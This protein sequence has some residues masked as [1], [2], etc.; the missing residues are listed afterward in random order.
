MLEYASWDS[1]STFF[2]CF[3]WGNICGAASF[4]RAKAS[5]FGDYLGSFWGKKEFVAEY[6]LFSF[7]LISLVFL[8]ALAFGIALLITYQ[9]DKKTFNKLTS[10]IMVMSFLLH[11][12]SSAVWNRWDAGMKE[13]SGLFSAKNLTSEHTVVV[14]FSVLFILF[15]IAGLVFHEFSVSNFAAGF[16]FLNLDAIISFNLYSSSLLFSNFLP[17][18]FGPGSILGTMIGLNFVFFVF[19]FLSACF[20]TLYKRVI[21]G[22]FIMFDEPKEE[23]KYPVIY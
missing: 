3:V 2:S 5:S 22:K 14:V 20:K 17:S 9:N 16:L 21:E 4:C 19:Y 10:G 7:S 18:L 1:I 12:K 8:V 23:K 15:L 13:M 6:S 11:T